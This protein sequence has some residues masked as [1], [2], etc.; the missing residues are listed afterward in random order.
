[1]LA[2]EGGSEDLP[3]VT[4]ESASSSYET[5]DSSSAADHPSDSATR[6]PSDTSTNVVPLDSTLKAPTAITDGPE[7][8][9]ICH[10]WFGFSTKHSIVELYYSLLVESRVQHT[11]ARHCFPTGPSEINEDTF[12]QVMDLMAQAC[13]RTNPDLYCLSKRPPRKLFSKMR[14][15]R[16]LR[17]GH[18]D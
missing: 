12:Y 6:A 10:D 7:G 3:L 11:V 2:A 15:Q 9:R 17:Q 14:R 8:D 5:C 4:K 16:T 18:A 13:E 1:M